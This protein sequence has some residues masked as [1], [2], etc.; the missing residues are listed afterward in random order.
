MEKLEGGLT[1][2]HDHLLTKKNYRF[3]LYFLGKSGFFF[4]SYNSLGLLVPGS[5]DIF[6]IRFESGKPSIYVSDLTFLKLNSFSNNK[7]VN[8]HI[9]NI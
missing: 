7:Y 6:G 9:Y 2:L 4:S 5:H 8:I 1:D 3:F